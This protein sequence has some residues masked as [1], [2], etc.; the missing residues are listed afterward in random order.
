MSGTCIDYS[1]L[2]SGKASVD[3]LESTLNS[4]KAS[5]GDVRSFPPEYPNRAHK[6]HTYSRSTRYRMQ[7]L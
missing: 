6:F 2:G 7:N 4:L 1:C 5:A 3:N